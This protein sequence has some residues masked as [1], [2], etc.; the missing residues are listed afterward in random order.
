MAKRQVTS[1]NQSAA[2]LYNWLATNTDPAWQR[3]KALLW[4]AIAGRE[5]P[6]LS[7]QWA[8]HF[9]SPAPPLVHE[10]DAVGAIRHLPAAIFSRLHLEA[11]AAGGI[12]A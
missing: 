4:Q 12:V 9:L 10:R 3:E 6:K 11:A 1:G 5:E 2:A 7:E 8:A